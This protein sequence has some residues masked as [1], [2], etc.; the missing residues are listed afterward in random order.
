MPAPQNVF[1]CY[2]A[3]QV[4]EANA[5]FADL[6]FPI[7][8]GADAGYQSAYAPNRFSSH[9][10]RWSSILMTR[11]RQEREE[12]R[13]ILQPRRHPLFDRTQL[14]SILVCS[15]PSAS[16]EFEPLHISIRLQPCGNCLKRERLSPQRRSR[17]VVDLGFFR[18]G[19]LTQFN[20]FRLRLR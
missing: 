17:N 9:H 20:F 2:R 5:S 4:L 6:N 18:T 10:Q 15:S 3:D 11:S 12:G 16:F 8:T 14:I 19:L 7:L 1:G 13:V